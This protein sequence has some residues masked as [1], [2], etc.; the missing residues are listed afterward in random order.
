M[1]RRRFSLAAVSALV[2]SAFA[3][4]PWKGNEKMNGKVFPCSGAGRW[5][6]ADKEELRE[7]VDGFLDRAQS[8][9]A[10]PLA[11]I[12]PHAGYPY[13]GAGA[14]ESYK[15]FAGRKIKR[16]IVLGLSHYSAFRGVSVLSGYGYYNTPL[17]DIRINQEGCDFL[18]SQKH[19]SYRKEAHAPEHS[20]ENQLPFIQRVLPQAEIVPCI[21]GDLGKTGFREAGASVAGLMDRDTVMAVS[22]DFTH[23]GASFG[24]EPFTGDIRK[25]L[26]KLDKGAIGA[27]VKTDFEAFADYLDRTGA[28][29]CGRNPISLMICA[30]KG[31]ARGRLLKYYTSSDDTGD[32]SHAVC[33]ASVLMEQA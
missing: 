18:L 19:F 33:Y 12:A 28:T 5:F 32:F 23:Y 2:A 31:K 13:S 21:V 17:G 26:E 29:I 1:D 7:T 14:G 30:L 27:I 24:Y 8:V 15:V 10:H 4:K 3:G 20:L 11:V 25:N 16:V 22:S 6:P 9:S